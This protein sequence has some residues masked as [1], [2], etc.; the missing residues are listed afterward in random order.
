[1]QVDLHRHLTEFA[2]VA[3]DRGEAGFKR[4][5]QR[6][7]N[8]DPAP[9]VETVPAPVGERHLIIRGT[10]YGFDEDLVFLGTVGHEA[11]NSS[12][13]DWFNFLCS[14]PYCAADEIISW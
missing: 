2:A 10:V 7:P 5:V 6:T 14:S 12:E 8:D 3:V 4:T 1:M 11:K 13:Q 9:C